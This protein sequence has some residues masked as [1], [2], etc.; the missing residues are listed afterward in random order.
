MRE[1]RRQCCSILLN[2]CLD[3]GWK[4]SCLPAQEILSFAPAVTSGVQFSW[5]SQI[6]ANSGHQ[7]RPSSFRRVFVQSLSAAFLAYQIPDCFTFLKNLFF[8]LFVVSLEL[9][10]VSCFLPFQTGSQQG[11]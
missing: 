11:W 1:D 8:L 4:H 10:L 3:P 5:D 6:S 7:Q 2:Y 9:V